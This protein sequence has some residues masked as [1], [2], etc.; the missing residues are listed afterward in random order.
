MSKVISLITKNA[1][2]EHE[3]FVQLD[4]IFL[5]PDFSKCG[6]LKK[7]LSFIV[8]ETLKGNANCL[9]EYTI[10]INVLEK[11]SNF[12]PQQNCIVRIHACRLRN[13]LSR[14]YEGAG[15]NDRLVIH[16]PKGKYVPVFL[17]LEEWQNEKDLHS[18]GIAGVNATGMHEPFTYAIVPFTCA[19]ENMFI[20]A[21]S[22]DLCMQI[23]SGISQFKNVPV[24]AYQAVKPLVAMHMDLRELAAV[25]GCNHIITGGTQY[26]GDKVRINVQIIDCNTYRQLW[27]KMYE[28]NLTSGDPFV[29]QDE[30]CH[31]TIEQVR[32]LSERFLPVAKS[33]GK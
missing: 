10:A 17:D 25:I 14:Y 15:R 1:F 16:I 6:V 8:H 4:R 27:S 30:I 22:E 21:F 9:K 3:I 18:P 5:D 26:L 33:C 28:G 31:Y 7:F 12:N 13:A 20:R 29:M 23:C 19:T 2:K 24:I 11:P 32:M